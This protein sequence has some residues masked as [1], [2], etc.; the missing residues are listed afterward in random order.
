MGSVSTFT[1]RLLAPSRVAFSARFQLVFYHSIQP[2]W[3]ASSEGKPVSLGRSLFWDTIGTL[4]PGFI[5]IV[6]GFR[7]VDCC[8]MGRKAPR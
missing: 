4:A 8:V 5:E 3:G 1:K 6:R 2:M 7:L